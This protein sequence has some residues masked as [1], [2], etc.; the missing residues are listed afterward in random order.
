MKAQHPQKSDKWQTKE[1]AWFTALQ[2]PKFYF[3][4]LRIIAGSVHV[5]LSLVGGVGVTLLLAFQRNV[6][7]FPEHF[8]PVA[9]GP[10]VQPS[11]NV[12]AL[13]RFWLPSSGPFR[14]GGG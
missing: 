4:P 5:F 12:A 13:N 9:P 10:A 8:M 11:L 1:L 3:F 6:L 2:L 7:P 14:T